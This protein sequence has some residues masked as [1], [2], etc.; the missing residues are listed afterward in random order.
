MS[1]V[2]KLVERREHVV[3]RAYRAPSTPTLDALVT[4][5]MDASEILQSQA[6]RVEELEGAL[7][8]I[9]DDYMTS[10]QH[11][12]GYVLIP[13]AKFEQLRSAALQPRVAHER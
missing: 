9:A 1:E 2:E 3:S 11:H 13:T 6:R 4:W 10:E 7:S 8:G 12:P 5:T